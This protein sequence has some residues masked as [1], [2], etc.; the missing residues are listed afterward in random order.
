[1]IIL[2]SRRFRF[3]KRWLYRI[4]KIVDLLK[5]IIFYLWFFFYFL[6]EFYDSFEIL[7]FIFFVFEL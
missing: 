1:M 6:V 3:I 4:Y 2:V 5:K 7:I